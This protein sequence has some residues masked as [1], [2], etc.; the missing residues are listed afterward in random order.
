MQSETSSHLRPVPTRKFPRLRSNGSN[1]G[2]GSPRSA[3]SQVTFCSTETNQ[4]LNA[5]NIQPQV[6][7]V[8]QKRRCPTNLSRQSD[9]TGTLAAVHTDL[10]LRPPSLKRAHSGVS[11]M[12]AK[13]RRSPTNSSP[14]SGV[15]SRERADCGRVWLPSSASSTTQLPVGVGDECPPF[16]MLAVL[17]RRREMED[18]LRVQSQVIT[19]PRLCAGPSH[20]SS[21]EEWAAYASAAFSS[22]T[23]AAQTAA[24][25][26]FGVF[27]GHGGVGVRT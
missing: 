2:E 15:E 18:F 26:Y 13:M 12:T 10:A 27:D 24:L 19:V 8:R 3:A 23:I 9:D 20:R 16:G 11:R 14:G 5:T 7:L 25:H 22:P 6:D 1:G 17:G 21:P 4:H